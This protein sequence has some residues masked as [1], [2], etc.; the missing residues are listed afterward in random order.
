MD[1]TF[2]ILEYEEA[3]DPDVVF[4]ENAV[5]G[6]FLEKDDDLD[7][8]RTIFEHLRTAALP[9][10]RSVDVISARTKEFQ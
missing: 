1:G 5:G 9:P 3:V 6:L 10:D 8:Y 7:R 2:S 4:A